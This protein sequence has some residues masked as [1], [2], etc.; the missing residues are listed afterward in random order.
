MEVLFKNAAP[1]Q[2]DIAKSALEKCVSNKLSLPNNG[3]VREDELKEI[4]SNLLI[5]IGGHTHSHVNMALCLEKEL[6]VELEE[7]YIRLKRWTGR[8]IKWF[9]YPFGKKQHV[10]AF[11]T[12]AVRKAG[13]QGA[14]TT[15]M[16]YIK[17]N[18]IDLYRIP[19][20]PV[21]GGWDMVKFKSRFGGVDIVKKMKRVF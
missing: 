10:N 19:R 17:K 14:V 9:A 12:E 6:K 5:T 1:T 13:Y 21:A 7:N 3:M 15:E 11:A 20:L 8:D 16:E 18:T 2:R 4:S